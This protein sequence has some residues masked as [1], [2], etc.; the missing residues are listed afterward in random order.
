VAFRPRRLVPTPR[1]L[2]RRRLPSPGLK[3][4]DSPRPS[5]MVRL[6]STKLLDGAQPTLRMRVVAYAELVR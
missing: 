6:I 1:A 2:M 5:E 3:G 4:K